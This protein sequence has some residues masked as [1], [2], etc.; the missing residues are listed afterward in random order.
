MSTGEG[1]VRVDPHADDDRLAMGLPHKVVTRLPLD[2]DDVYQ[3]LAPKSPKE[4]VTIAESV[5]ES[6]PWRYVAGT[7]LAFAGDPRIR[8]ECPE[9]LDIPGG[10]IPIG[11]PVSAVD[12]VVREWEQQGVQRD[13]IVKECPRHT[14]EIRPF[15]M[16]RHPVTNYEY[17]RFMRDT[18]RWPT[19]TSWQF[20]AYPHER[21][22]HP[23]WT[24]TERDA[25]SYATWL[26]E[27]TA[28]SFRLPTEA[29]WE[30]A[31]AGPVPREYP[32]GDAFDEHATNTVEAGPLSTTPVG[33]YPMGRSPFGV[34]DMAGNVEEFVADDYAPYPGGESVEDDLTTGRPRYRVTRGGSFS[35]F[36]DLARCRRRHGQYPRF[37]YAVGFRLVEDTA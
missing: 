17:F 29:E 35:R 27:R 34:D 25:D 19:P 36:G 4:L 6:F 5:E 31:A 2:L 20:G 24:V 8:P 1:E 7:L 30:Y 15:R 11:L 32:W 23:V 10:M 3:A 13:W 37:M 28:R 14:V 21:A 9:M 33:I 12:A 22:N 16:M 26:S 18:E